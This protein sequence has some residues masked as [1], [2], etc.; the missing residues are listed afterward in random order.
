L[1]SATGFVLHYL[2]QAANYNEAASLA[3]DESSHL[4]SPNEDLIFM[5]LRRSTFVAELAEGKRVLDIGCVNHTLSTRQAKYWLHGILRERAASL[6][7]LDYEKDQVEALRREGFN[8]VCADATD[9]S[10]GAQ[11]DL[12]VAGEIIEHLT[13]PGKLLDCARR[14]LAPRGKLVLTCPNANN[15]LYFLEN[16]LM[17][18]EQDNT[19][20]TCLFTPTTM[21]VLL[22]KCGYRPVSFHFVAENLAYYKGSVGHKVLAY[23]MWFA[24]L[25]AGVFRPCLCKNFITVAEPV[26]DSAAHGA[27]H[28]PPAPWTKKADCAPV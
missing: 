12:I 11:F 14:H 16:C 19:D 1:S 13:C 17:G 2:R 4:G 23:T 8:V 24:Q 26:D 15:L 7:G 27:E 5:L 25:A 9:F 18:H 3:E 21:G 28:S 20:H 6:V 10:L 22:R